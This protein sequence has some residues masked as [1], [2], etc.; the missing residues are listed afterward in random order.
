M[1]KLKELLHP[2]IYLGINENNSGYSDHQSHEEISEKFYNGWIELLESI[3][4]KNTPIYKIPENKLDLAINKGIN[5]KIR[6]AI[7]DVSFI[8]SVDVLLG[9]NEKYGFG[10][11][12][13][14]S[15]AENTSP[16]EIYLIISPNFTIQDL[17]KIKNEIKNIANHEA[18]HIIKTTQKT[19]QLS[20]KRG[21]FSG[22]EKKLW[23][24]YH[25]NRNEFHAY[26]AQTNNELKYIKE[27]HK[28]IS[29][30]KALKLSK[31]WRRYD[32]D[33]FDKAPKLRNKMLSKIAN[34]W[35][36]LK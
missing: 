33:I 23:Y 32:A 36:K 8:M 6:I 20:F 18:V 30:E 16:L 5:F 1:I 9:I 3:D 21:E 26:I 24:K 34:Y 14:A 13:G 35:N 25:I 28:D 11:I 29:F 27:T 7:E 22:Y 4:D 2:T 31:T 12:D 10:P 15:M 17:L 19:H